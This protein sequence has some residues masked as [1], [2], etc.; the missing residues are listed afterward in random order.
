MVEGEHGA[1]IEGDDDAAVEGD[2]DAAVTGDEDAAVKGGDED[3]AVKDEEPVEGEGDAA[4]EDEDD[5]G[6]TVEHDVGLHFLHVGKTGGTSVKK[7]VRKKNL[8]TLPDGR[9][10][11]M[12]RHQVALPEV[13]GWHESN[14]GAIFLRHPVSRF[15]SGFNSRLREGAP[16][17]LIPWKPPERIAFGHFPTAN[18]LA[19]AL[20]AADPITEDRAIAAMEAM[21]HTR[22][23]LTYWL[24]DVPYLQRRLDRIAFIGFQ[25]HYAEDVSRFFRTLGV[26][27]VRVVHQHQAPSS[28]TTSLSDLARENLERWYADDVVIYEWAL[29]Q[30]DRWAG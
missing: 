20:S 29:A 12:H 16:Q 8:S 10:L 9:R 2:D 26:E 15:V 23:R 28:S 1:T 22:M 21:V 25:E 3:S 4:V 13:L 11:V 17:K 27:K 24:R 6:V 19:E 30:R 18:D 14:V 5:A 7:M